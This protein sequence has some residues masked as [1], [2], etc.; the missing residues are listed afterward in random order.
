VST[1]V[2]GGG[3]ALVTGASGGLGAEFARQLAARGTNVVLCARREGVLD[4]LA[5]RLE[6]EHAVRTAVV[7]ADLSLPGAAEPAW[8][9][10]ADGREIELLVNN[11][12]AGAHGR[13]V[14]VERER[15]ASL[16]ALDCVAVVE[17]AHLALGEMLGRG[18]G[19]ILN[20]GSIA[21]YQPVPW[22][23]TYGAAKAFVRSFSLALSDECR[24]TGVRV[25]CVSPGTVPTGFQDA[26]GFRVGRRSGGVLPAATVVRA[27]L[28]ALERGD[29][30][31]VPG[32]VNRVATT[33]AGLVPT[34]LSTRA[35]RRVN[36]R[37]GK[38]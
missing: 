15:H 32:W 5:L 30:E 21:A 23:A 6:R 24:G 38:G 7:A 20:V 3:W 28:R 29:D 35:A 27:A 10:A 26:A 18:R 17:L 12:G 16:I 19:A 1:V 22:L 9:A 36:R 33:L 37:R 31:V 2:P 11:A 4:E 13:F 14:Q 34:R 8:R 25:L